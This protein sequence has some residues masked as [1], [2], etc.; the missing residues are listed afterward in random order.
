VRGCGRGDGA[1]SCAA[2]RPRCQHA[3]HRSAAK[4]TAW[5]LLQEHTS[6]M[7]AHGG[8]RA[9]ARGSSVA[10]ARPGPRGPRTRIRRGAG[11]PPPSRRGRQSGAARAR[12]RS[13]AAAPTAPGGG[14]AQHLRVSGTWGKSPGP[15]DSRGGAG[16]QAG[17]APPA[18]QRCPDAHVTPS[19]PTWTLSYLAELSPEQ[20]EAAMC[21][22][23]HVRVIA[24]GRHA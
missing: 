15:R 18:P 3:R 11:P 4:R 16:E 10:R 22:S 19:H 24:G 6:A 1:F 12:A 23:Q 20:T 8:G 5:L 9:V 7:P 14:G 17:P 13:S 2:G 21:P